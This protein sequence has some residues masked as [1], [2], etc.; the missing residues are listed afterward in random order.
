V[1]FANELARTI[2]MVEQILVW[3]IMI[4]ALLSFFPNIDPYHPVVRGLDGLVN[5]ITRPFRALLPPMGGID[6]SPILAI[7]ALQVGAKILAGLLMGLA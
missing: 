2:L 5:P 3:M 4:R 6:L 7:F 1:P